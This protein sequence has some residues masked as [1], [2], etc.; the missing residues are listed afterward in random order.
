MVHQHEEDRQRPEQ[1][2]AVEPRP[3]TC[4]IPGEYSVH[5]RIMP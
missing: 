4:G 5:V 1:I 3:A 2:D